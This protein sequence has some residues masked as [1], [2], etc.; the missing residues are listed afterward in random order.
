MTSASDPHTGRPVFLLQASSDQKLEPEA[1]LT[2]GCQL[3]HFQHLPAGG[4]A[5][6]WQE[7]GFCGPCLV[8]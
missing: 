3:P 2:V 5:M 6:L 1:I 4:P 8:F 7:V